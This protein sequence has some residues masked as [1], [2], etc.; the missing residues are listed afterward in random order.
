MKNQLFNFLE[1]TGP[2]FRDRYISE[3]LNFS[4]RD[5]EEKLLQP[6]T[7]LEKKLELPY[8]SQKHLVHLIGLE[9]FIKQK[10]NKYISA[11]KRL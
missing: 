9:I 4:D 3:I 6:K 10:S 2:D 11:Q 7:W 8:G 1:N 5:I